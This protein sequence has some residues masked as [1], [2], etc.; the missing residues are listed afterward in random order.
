MRAGGRGAARICEPMP[1][2]EINRTEK[3]L[4]FCSGKKSNKLERDLKLLSI[5][6]P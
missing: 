3:N 4:L 6:A 5:L 2:G 1:Y